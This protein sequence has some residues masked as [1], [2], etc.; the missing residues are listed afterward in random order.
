MRIRMARTVWTVEMRCRYRTQKKSF[1]GVWRPHA[2]S[3][4]DCPLS[5]HHN[6]LLI[7]FFFFTFYISVF[8]SI[9]VLHRATY[10]YSLQFHALQPY[11]YLAPIVTKPSFLLLT[12]HLSIEKIDSSRLLLT[13]TLLE[14]ANV[15]HLK[16]KE[17]GQKFF[18][19]SLEA[20]S[21]VG[22][23]P[24]TKSNPIPSIHRL[25]LRRAEREASH[26]HRR[27]RRGWGR[28]PPLPLRLRPLPPQVITH[29]SSSTIHQL[30]LHSSTTA[31][32][33]SARAAQVWGPGA[34]PTRRRAFRRR[35]R[36]LAAPHSLIRPLSAAQG[37]RPGILLRPRF[38]YHPLRRR[39]LRARLRPRRR[40]RGPHSPMTCLSA[41]G[42]DCGAINH[43]HISTSFVCSSFYT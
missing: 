27:R 30:A 32:F 20:S 17:N 38:G 25:R 39:L 34:Q 9:H 14:R 23:G 42:Q 15:F 36:P 21:L 1:G 6:Y 19:A 31:P 37:R 18:C 4:P 2:R 12:A 3:G 35:R 29:P 28:A 24:N 16:K 13:S 7:F 5:L 43:V 41:C 11:V 40:C 10:A 22:L 33:F 26:G 8:V